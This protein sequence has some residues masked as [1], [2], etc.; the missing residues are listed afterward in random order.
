MIIMNDYKLGSGGA[1]NLAAAHVRQFKHLGLWWGHCLALSKKAHLECI[2][3]SNV[4]S[5]VSV[6]DG[7][8]SL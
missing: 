2:N 3:C 4:S 1:L 6:F 5:D 7:G 8:L